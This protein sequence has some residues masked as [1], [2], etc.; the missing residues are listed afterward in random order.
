MQASKH[1]VTVPHPY[2]DYCESSGFEQP[3]HLCLVVVH[4]NSLRVD[5]HY[6][7]TGPR[8]AD[9]VQ[10]RLDPEMFLRAHRSNFV[11]VDRIAEIRTDGDGFRVVLK[12]GVE[13]PMSRTQ[14]RKLKRDIG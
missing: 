5:R 1:G 13:L 14:A 6:I 3:Y 8:R 2:R 4:E 10:T 11:N 9:V 12:G 7:K